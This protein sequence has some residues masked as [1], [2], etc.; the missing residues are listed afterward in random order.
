MIEGN[1][2]LLDSVWD[3]HACHD[4]IE[5]LWIVA[6]LLWIKKLTETDIDGIRCKWLFQGIWEHWESERLTCI[7]I[8]FVI[9]RWI[10]KSSASII[11][12]CA[13]P[14]LF[15]ACHKL[16]GKS[17]LIDV[18][19]SC[20]VPWGVWISRNFLWLRSMQRMA[21]KFVTC[22]HLSSYMHNRIITSVP[23]L[24]PCFPYLTQEFIG[25]VL[26]IFHR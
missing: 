9:R 24:T 12:I 5:S 11:T 14:V 20:Q 15:E 21:F 23:A 8:P 25:L 2:I 19:C 10:W 7:I 18:Y 22:G 26:G 16:I 3:I 6:P 17:S 4:H 1:W 13:S